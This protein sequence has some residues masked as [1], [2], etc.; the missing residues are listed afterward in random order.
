[1]RT[2]LAAARRRYHRER[3][4]CRPSLDDPR[5]YVGLFTLSDLTTLARCRCWPLPPP[6]LAWLA[7][8]PRARGRRRRRCAERVA[9]VVRDVLAAELPEAVAY[10]GRRNGRTRG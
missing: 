7:E 8:P 1:V 3:R 10:L 2:V 9:A 6:A 5:S 4:V